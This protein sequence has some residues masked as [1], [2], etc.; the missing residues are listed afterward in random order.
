MSIVMW[1]KPAPGTSIEQY[2]EII[3]RLE[4][5]GAGAPEGRLYHVTFVGD[6]KL[7]TLDVW[8]SREEFETFVETMMPIVQAVGAQPSPPIIY[9]VV[10]V[11]EGA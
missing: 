7:G 8:N 1:M 2:E 10:N 6:G 5:A 9:E 4:E 3:R 11:I